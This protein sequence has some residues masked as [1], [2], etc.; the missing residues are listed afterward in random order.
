M[1]KLTCQDISFDGLGV[2]RDENKIVFVDGMLPNE[3]ADVEIYESKKN[4]EF[5]NL[6]HLETT[7]DQR[8]E[9]I[10]PHFEKCGGCSTMHMS[11]DLV[12]EFKQNT[13][14]QVFNKMHDNI[15]VEPLI[16]EGDLLAYRSKLIFPVARNKNEVISGPYK[17]NTHHV[18][19]AKRCL[20][21]SEQGQELHN[22]IL[23][24]I[25][26]LGLSIYN[27]TLH[28]GTIRSI[29]YRRNQNDQ[30]MVVIVAM[31]ETK[32]EPLLSFISEFSYV[33]S[34]YANINNKKS[35]VLLSKEYLHFA[36]DEYLHENING[37]EYVISPESF[38][39]INH[40]ITEL[41]YNK[42]IEL[43]DLKGNEVVLDAYCGTGT[44]T[45]NLAK[46][47]K[48]VY[49]IEQVQ[50][51]VIDAKINAINN[52]IDNVSFLCGDV[53][54]TYDKIEEKIDVVVV[55]PARKGCSEYFMNFIVEKSIK[56]VVYMSCNAAT[57]ARDVKIL[58]DAGYTFNKVYT[59]DMF[60]QTAHVETLL[61]ATKA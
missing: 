31:E 11:N 15:S 21:L 49:G 17:K 24:K 19:N 38:F 1:K 41:M 2:C 60:P 8:I 61:V 36:K 20:M 22:A 28:T 26:E 5:A 9:P 59:Y 18:V 42:I 58:T 33:V 35:N 39:Q 50:Q 51:A 34:V 7:S 32:L 6:V 46:K 12:K 10:C 16:Q 25:V 54:R 57:Q 30:Y 4:Y 14:Q 48:Y 23:D 29:M 3:V 45:L 47:A 27:E 40:G 52:K 37:I 43:A 53:S 56:K 13:V 44:I 55:D